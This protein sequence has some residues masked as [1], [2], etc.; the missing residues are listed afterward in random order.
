MY[1]ADNRLHVVECKSFVDGKEGTAVLNDALFKLQAIM[2][3]KFGLNAKSYLYTKSIVER[4][5]ALSR[6]QEFGITIVDGKSL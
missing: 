3:T 2:K 5:S 6:A 1:I 4:E